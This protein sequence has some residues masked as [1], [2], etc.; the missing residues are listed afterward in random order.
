MSLVVCKHAVYLFNLKGYNVKDLVRE[1]P[2]IGWN[3]GLVCQL[4][5]KLYRVLSKSGVLPAAADDAASAQL[6][7]LT[8]L[9]NC[10]FPAITRREIIFTHR[11]HNTKTLLSTKNYQNWLINVEDIASQSRHSIQHDW[12]DPISGV[13]VSPGSGETLVRRCGITNHHSIA[14][15]LS[16][17]SVKKYQNRL[18]Y[19]EVIARNVS[20]V[21][22]IQCTLLVQ[23]LLSWC[24]NSRDGSKGDQG[25]APSQRY[26]PS[27]PFKRICCV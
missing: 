27:A 10:F 25:H 6:T 5:Q 15:S 7:T 17:I 18:L 14:Y 9:M 12:K 23:F 2:S 3:V 1:F 20:V 11:T 4:L 19:V 26:G 8:L 16:N 22:E 21:F 13:H 24:S